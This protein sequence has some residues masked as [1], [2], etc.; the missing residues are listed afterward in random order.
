[1]LFWVVLILAAVAGALYYFQ[2]LG[3]AAKQAAQA[4][5]EKKEDAAADAA[6]AP[7]ANTIGPSDISHLSSKL[8]PASNHMDV[9]L[10]VAT[11]PENI[12]YG[13]KAYQLKE[14]T[15][16]ERI[17]E[18]LEEAKKSLSRGS[19][20]EES[21]EMFSLDDDGWADDDADDEKAKAAAKA[22]EEKKKERERLQQ[23]VGKAKIKLEG[24]DEG[25]I[26]Q[27]WIENL[28]ASRGLWPPKYMGFL[29]DQTFDYEGKQVSALDHPG[30]R[31][32]LCMIHGRLHSILLN[33]HPE[34]CKLQRRLGQKIFLLSN[35]PL[36]FVF[37]YFF[38]SGGWI[39]ANVRSNLLQRGC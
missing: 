18:D 24:I 23:A 2:Q 17:K 15:R 9:L 12:A 19:S 26:G 39:Q 37:F 16:R 27:K 1:M 3:K 4:D 36:H 35:S 33:S 30:L 6:A 8:H 38:H 14:A 29:K 5:P 10:A 20:K 21:T 28:M 34:L 25:V 31:R 22:E 7:P 13:L 32:N 11:T